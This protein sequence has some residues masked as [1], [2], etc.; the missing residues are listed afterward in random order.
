[1]T[2]RADAVVCCSWQHVSEAST[3]S[4]TTTA[5]AAAEQQHLQQQQQQQQQQQHPTGDGEGAADRCWPSGAQPLARLRL[6]A[7]DFLASSGPAGGGGGGGGGAA[8]EEED[9][10]EE[11]GWENGLWRVEAATGAVDGTVL[12]VM[13]PDLA[14]L[15]AAL[16]QQLHKQKGPLR[17]GPATRR[18]LQR[19]LA[20]LVHGLR[21]EL[22]LLCALVEGTAPDPALVRRVWLAQPA[23][24]AALYLLGLLVEAGGGG[25]GQGGLL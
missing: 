10:E 25:G 22:D 3:T 21:E 20:D 5:A 24:A 11:E 17:P 7:D 12:E 8:E 13:G 1:V 14:S 23:Q 18:A 16:R 15:C 19:G 6:T 4:S 9:D 2:G